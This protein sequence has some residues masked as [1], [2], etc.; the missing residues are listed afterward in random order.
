MKNNCLDLNKENFIRILKSLSS[1]YKPI[2]FDECKND[3]GSSVIL[4]H[5]IDLS[6]SSSLEIAKLEKEYGF[7]STFFVNLHS[8]FY[9][10][11][12]KNELIKLKIISSL[13]HEIGIHF[14][15]VFWNIKNEKELE[16]KLDLEKSIFKGTL[17]I[18]TRVFSFHNPDRLSLSFTKF[19]YA[20]MINAYSKDIK[21]NYKYCSDS[22]GYWRHDNMYKV[23]SSQ[24]FDK[25]HL[26]THPG[27]WTDYEN[28]PRSKVFDI[29][30]NRL[31]ITIKNYD[32][33]LLKFDRENLSGEL[34]KLLFVKTNY[35]NLYGKIDLTWNLK[36][37]FEILNELINI[38]TLQLN[39]INFKAFNN[40]KSYFEL[41]ENIKKEELP[42]RLDLILAKI[43]KYDDNFKDNLIRLKALLNRVNRIYF[44]EKNEIDSIVLDLFNLIDDFGSKIN[45][46]N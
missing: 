30:L 15:S 44:M 8:D 40:D 18:N 21:K 11:L 7:K 35:E 41:G 27:W 1:K 46:L 39:E 24:S 12:E 42:K 37:H 29:L 4:R 31:E 34:S 25:L 10:P 14:D 32:K 6:V 19:R 28:Y 9:N 45:N 43:D 13:G 33:N 20:N 17:G 36:Y 38:I 22:N 26:L 3:F 23:V 16:E 2:F 5:D